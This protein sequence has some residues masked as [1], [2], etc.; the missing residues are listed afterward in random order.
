MAILAVGGPIVLILPFRWVDPPTTAFVL[1]AEV[2]AGHDIGFDRALQWTDL[3]DISPS[4]PLAVLASEDQK[5]FVHHGFDT[6]AIGDALADAGRGGRLRGASTISQQVAKNLFLWPS[7]SPVRK[8]LEAHLTLFVEALWPKRR[9]L[10]VYL[11]IAEFGDA[12]FGVS[13]AASQFFG[14]TPD[15]LDAE[16]AARLAAV[17]PSPRMFKVQDPSPQVLK[18]QAWILDQMEGLRGT[19]YT[20]SLTEGATD[21]GEE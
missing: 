4:L 18:R 13:A 5:F 1:R 9:I 3:D 10:E 21:S 2:L 19:I 12:M 11:N 8:G 16:Q 6:E 14:V 17:L 20:A 15:L 7:R